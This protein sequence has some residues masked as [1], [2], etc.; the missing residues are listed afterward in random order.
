MIQEV[1]AIFTQVATPF[2]TKVRDPVF[3]EFASVNVSDVIEIV[4][5]F[6]EPLMMVTVVPTVNDTLEFAGKV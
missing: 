2:A 5:L 1:L 3:A 4:T 6:A